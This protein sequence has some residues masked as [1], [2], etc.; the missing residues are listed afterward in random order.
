MRT[1]AS[2]AIHTFPLAVRPVIVPTTVGV[3]IIVLDESEIPSGHPGQAGP[4]VLFTELARVNSGRSITNAIEDVASAA[5]RLLNDPY[6]R[7]L[8]AIDPESIVWLEM[9]SDALSYNAIGAILTV[10]WADLEWR[11]TRYRNPQWTR[12]VDRSTKDHNHIP[13]PARLARRLEW[14]GVDL[15]ISLMAEAEKAEA[16]F[17]VELRNRPDMQTDTSILEINP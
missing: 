10:D 2:H 5:R 17:H 11:G 3:T 12:I 6:G 1:R 16:A 14:M 4:V 13:I 7:P 15:P 8:S 9:Y